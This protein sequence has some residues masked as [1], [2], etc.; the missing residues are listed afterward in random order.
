[1]LLKERI[2]YILEYEFMVDFEA[3]RLGIKD[4]FVSIPVEET[5]DDISLGAFGCSDTAEGKKVIEEINQVL[6]N[7]RKSEEYRELLN[8]LLPKDPK[9]VERYWKE[10]QKILKIERIIKKKV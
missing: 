1:M 6:I 8:F 10:H 2:D 7:K 9:R 5:L 3:E 4:Q